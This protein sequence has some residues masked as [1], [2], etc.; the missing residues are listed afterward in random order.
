MT[1]WSVD[2]AGDVNGDGFADVIMGAISASPLGRPDAGQSYV[3]L[4][5]A[6]FA[7]PLELSTLNGTNGFQINGV[8][9]GD[10]SGWSVG[11]AGD[12]NG[13]GYDDVIV[14]APYAS[15]NG[16]YQAGESYVVYGSIGMSASSV[17]VSYSTS[18]LTSHKAYYDDALVQDKTA[19]G[20]Y[21]FFGNKKKTLDVA[22]HNVT[23]HSV[24]PSMN[25]G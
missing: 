19:S 6:T 5:N 21:S 7:T 22:T 2:G 23:K 10:F 18:R 15:P 3:V 14:G 12:V 11:G 20:R 24:L 8:K 9:P 4:G 25:H 17:P 1:G 13:D 16:S